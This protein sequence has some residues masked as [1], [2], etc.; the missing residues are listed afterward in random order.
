MKLRWH[1]MTMCV[2]YC[3]FWISTSAT[4]GQYV[5]PFPGENPDLS[6]PYSIV[7]SV[8]CSSE[9]LTIKIDAAYEAYDILQFLCGN[10]NL[11]VNENDNRGYAY[12]SDVKQYFTP[13]KDSSIV[14]RARMLMANWPVD[15][16]PTIIALL[17]SNMRIRSEFKN[18][19]IIDDYIGESNRDFFVEILRDFCRITHF[20]IFY[21]N[22]SPFYQSLLSDY[23]KVIAGK[24]FTSD[25]ERYTGCEKAAYVF[26]LEPM[27]LKG[28]FGISLINKISSQE[29]AIM[30][31]RARKWV[32]TNP[33]F[34]DDE[35]ISTIYHEL[36]HSICNGLVDKHWK[37]FDK[38]SYQTSK[39]DAKLM[40]KNGY[41]NPPRWKTMVY[42]HIVRSIANRLT[43][44]VSTSIGEA[45]YSAQ[46]ETYGFIYL[47]NLCDALKKYENNRGLYPQIDSYMLQ[48]AEAFSK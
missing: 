36:A 41:G 28:N 34:Y 20:N 44:K 45:D 14:Q 13:Y 39:L 47:S 24:S 7:Q 5:T 4:Y 37:D 11:L 32:N 23:R 26:V 25:I 31:F 19:S 8:A 16:A 10:T 43:T 42:E 22:E 35:A 29:N 40:E 18:Q 33:I 21:S 12:L 48:L 38:Y 9:K 46:I 1:R 2:L 3:M 30:Y 17:D 6:N 27:N 15:A